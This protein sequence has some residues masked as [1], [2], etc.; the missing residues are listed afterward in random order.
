MTTTT[1]TGTEV[2]LRAQRMLENVAALQTHLLEEILRRAT[3][4]AT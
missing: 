4:F 2:L 1:R 3:E